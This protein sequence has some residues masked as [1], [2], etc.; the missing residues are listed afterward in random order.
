MSTRAHSLEYISSN[1]TSSCPKNAILSNCTQYNKRRLSYL[2]RF[3]S[4]QKGNKQ[5]QSQI[6]IVKRQRNT[7]PTDS[8]TEIESKPV[9]ESTREIT[10][11]V[12]RWIAEFR[13]RKGTHKQS[14]TSL[15]R[16]LKSTD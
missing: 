15:T 11:V 9:G 8:Q 14:F 10:N 16:Q 1:S 3:D 13:E 4:A 6:K 5:L 7:V 2:S 12:K